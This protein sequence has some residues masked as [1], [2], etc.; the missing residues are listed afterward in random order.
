MTIPQDL[1]L[2]TLRPTSGRYYSSGA[3]RVLWGGRRVAPV[4]PF[5]RAAFSAFRNDA[6]PRISISGIQEKVSLRFVNGVLAP[7]DHD[8]EYILKPVPRTLSG[9]LECIDDV[10]ANEHVSMQI[11]AQIFGLRTAA[12]GLV[13]FPDGEPAYIAKRFDRDASTGRK[14]AQEDFCQLAGKSRATHGENYKYDGSYEEVGCLLRQFSPAWRVDAERLFSQIVFNYAFGNG[15]AHL[16]NFSL[17]ETSFGDSALSPVYDLLCTSLHLPTESRCALECFNEFETESSRA[18]GFL[19][20]VD[21]LELAKRF[22]VREDAAIAIL[23][24][25][26]SERSAVEEMIKL[27]LLSEDAKQRYLMIVVDRARALVD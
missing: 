23:N 8:G 7:T 9:V 21:F 26:A 25:F 16:K 15:D 2:S 27:S 22:G 14:L 18:N 5:E 13:F 19:K 6:V 11:S 20:R 1:C 3:Q 24:R 4:L 10:P 17:L 12:C